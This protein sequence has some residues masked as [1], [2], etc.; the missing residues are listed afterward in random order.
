MARKGTTSALITSLGDAGLKTRPVG[1]IGAIT[2]RPIGAGYSIAVFFLALLSGISLAGILL[3]REASIRVAVVDIVSPVTDLSVVVIAL[4]AARR[5]SNHSRRLKLGWGAIAL[6]MFAYALG[7][8][9]W[10]VL[11]VGFTTAPFPS[12]ADG[13]YLAYFPI[14]LVGVYFLLDKPGRGELVKR[15]I[16][17][18]MIMVAAILGLSN[19]LIGPMIKSQTGVVVLA[20]SIL[21]AYPVGDLVLLAALLM[22]IYDLPEKQIKAPVY[23]LGAGLLAMIVSDSIYS[24]QTLL[25][26][27]AS[28]DVLDLGWI[29]GTVCIGLAG[30]AQWRAG[31]FNLAVEKTMPMYSLSRRYRT[32]MSFIPYTWLAGAFILLLSGVMG[33]TPLS[34]NLITLF[35]GVAVIICLALARQFIS[36]GE[37]SR[38]NIE[39]HR[40]VERVQSQAVALEKANLELEKDIDERKLVEQ[41]LRHSEAHLSEALR[42]ARMGYWEFD[43]VRDLY[44]FNDQFYSLLQTSA[45]QE[46]GYIMP[47]KRFFERFVH[48]QDAEF[49]DGVMKKASE[50]AEQDCTVQFDHRIIRTNGE[51]GYLYVL[52]RVHKDEQGRIVKTDGVCHDITE[53]VRS[54]EEIKK[55][56]GELES[57]SQ[58]SKAIRQAST[59]K[60]MLPL[61]LGTILDMLHAD[62]GAIWLFDPA[63]NELQLAFSKRSSGEIAGRSTSSEITGNGINGFAFASRHPYIARDYQQESS[64]PEAV[65]QS[66][67]AG[68]GG[69][70]IPIR[71]GQSVIGT[72]ELNVHLPRQL[73]PDE[74]HLLT[75]LSEIAGNAI[76][77]ITLHQQTERRLQQLTALS[78]IDRVISSTADIHLSLGLLLEHVGAQLGVDAT[79]VLLFNTT[80]QMLE[81]SIGRGFRTK[82][83]EQARLRLGEGYAGRAV[84]TRETIY[85]PDLMA[86]HDNPDFEKYAA[87]EQFVSYYGVPLIA[88][89]QVKGVLEIFQRSLLEP[90]KEWLDFLNSLVGQAAI[91]ID[92]TMQFESLQRS[93]SE[94]RQAYDETIEGWSRA[95]DLRDNETQGHTQRVTEMTVALAREAGFSEAD[96]VQVRWGALLH[97][98]G[99]MG[100]PDS[101]LLKAGPLSKEEWKT[102]KKHPVLA[103][104]MIA[105]IRYLRGALDIPYCHH[106][107][108]DGSGY[109]RG[110]KG[111]QIPLAARIFAVVGVWDALCSDRPYCSAWPN[112][113][114]TEYIR[115]G[116]GTHFDPRFV[117]VFLNSDILKV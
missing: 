117:E 114:V 88:R 1:A 67:P 98:I 42:M 6:A 2:H 10:A 53:R 3:I 92:S 62:D 77:R 100:V 79:D 21:L 52:A 48:P 27:Y 95:M 30:L 51:I 5:Y 4:I 13:F 37:N 91:A 71:A 45:R 9:T 61:L 28:G 75:I 34:M 50:T 84:L 65:R 96:L 105:P 97:D 43:A 47:A 115:S 101:I 41:A 99:K 40:Y 66:I 32:S 81:Y 39:L 8:A 12:I 49:I 113:K 11:E 89:G 63:T 60:E 74:I 59:L 35:A 29:L 31:H 112:E 55:R 70:A 69:A 80:L 83:F 111:E 24:Y 36:L 44:T 86:A 106:E 87:A 73:T 38:L 54:Q 102:M 7:D 107:K 90:D 19:Y 68:L 64:L 82:A 25:G 109:P 72:I 110:L 78:N 108:W 14:A 23:W 20:Q 22:L 18:S 16:D 104:E 15:I 57:V 56:L 94:L 58:I 46:G 76:Q 26:T 17:I 103:Y 93:N 85:V 116:S 33:W